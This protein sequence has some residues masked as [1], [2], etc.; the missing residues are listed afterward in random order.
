[1]PILAFWLFSQFSE[2][3]SK[4]V[5]RQAECPLVELGFWAYFM[6]RRFYQY[7][8][9]AALALWCTSAIAGPIYVYHESDGTKKFSTVPPPSG[10]RAQVFTARKSAFSW[11]NVKPHYGGKSY[12][13]LNGSKFDDVIQEASVSTGLEKSLLKAVIH[14]ESGFNPHAVSPKGAR[15]LMQLMPQTARDLGVRDSFS[16]KDNVYGGAK[17]LAYL[18]QRF[19]GN[20]THALAAYNAGMDNVDKYRGVPP[21]EETKNYVQSVLK[22]HARYKSMNG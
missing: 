17:Y 5:Q 9:T 12:F 18:L 20:L 19:R 10:V 14:A 3:Q 22:L 6:S 16:P 7:L 21:F 15:G 4:S 11:Y 8:L 1:M 13:K 2:L